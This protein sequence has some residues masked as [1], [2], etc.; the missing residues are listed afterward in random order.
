MNFLPQCP[1]CHGY[2]GLV[3]A[4]FTSKPVS[5]ELCVY[6]R[7]VEQGRGDEYLQK[8]FS[9]FEESV[10]E[11]KERRLEN[12]RKIRRLSDDLKRISRQ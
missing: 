12:E 9:E 6:N 3:Y 8:K 10:R 1:H 2:W 7:M 5:C 11:L 4:S